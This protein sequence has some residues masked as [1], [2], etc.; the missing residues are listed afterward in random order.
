MIIRP[1]IPIWVMA[2]I[3]GVLLVCKRKGVWP[4]IRQ[5]ILI[6]LLFALNLRP[7][8]VS[9]KS[10]VRVE[11]TN[12][13]VVFAVDDTIS[14]LAQDY[15]GSRT[16]LYGVNKDCCEIIDAVYGAKFSVITFNN[17]AQV[18]SPV[19]SDGNFA[20]STI[21]S[22]YPLSTYTAQGTNLSL[23][24]DVILK[25]LKKLRE[26]GDGSICLVFISDG[27][28]TNG[29]KL[30]SFKDVAKYVDCGAVLGYGTEKG[31]KMYYEEYGYKGDYVKDTS[32]YPEK[33]AIS[34]IDEKNLKAVAKDLGVK[35]YNMNTTSTDKMIEDL[36]ANLTKAEEVTEVEGYKDLYYFIA[37]P[38]V[39]LL[40]IEMLLL[41]KKTR[42]YS[43]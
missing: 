9:Q 27:E 21:E 33:D 11:K 31:G 25:H 34:K 7:Q 42:Q 4:Y 36:T 20:K 12:A 37:M 19:T 14:M 43:K 40:I 15:D 3:C 38:I 8:L 29:K 24:K 5:I 10:E 2:I 18:V 23:S 17:E 28:N 35:Y 22:I 30:E 26:K 41:K 1:M 6:L 32:S 39:L 13:Y 16:R